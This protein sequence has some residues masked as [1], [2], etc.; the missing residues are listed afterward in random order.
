P[1]LA[2][3][4]GD[5][6]P[7]IGVA[8]A[9]A[10]SVFD[11]DGP[12]PVLWSRDTKDFSSHATGSSVFDFEGDGVAEVIYGDECFVRVYRGTDGHVLLEIPNNTG[13]IH[14]YPLVADVDADGRS[15][16]LVVANNRNDLCSATYPDWA[17]GGG[18]RR[19]LFV[20]G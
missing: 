1:T 7:E 10:Y 14:E 4:D 12:A 19:G 9:T 16:I 18:L 3:F 15:E 5:N 17:A 13:T 2:D 8:G 11:P 6:L 20:Y